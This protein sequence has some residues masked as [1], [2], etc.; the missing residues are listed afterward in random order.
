MV[1]VLSFFLFPSVDTNRHIK[2]DPLGEEEHLQEQLETI[3][4]IIRC[5]FQEMGAKIFSLFD[6]LAG[7]FQK[8]VS[9]PNVDQNLLAL[10]EGKLAWLVYIIGAILGGRLN[11]CAATE[12]DSFDGNLCC[13]VLKLQTIHDQRLP[14]VCYF[15]SLFLVPPSLL[16]LQ[17]VGSRSIFFNF[18]YFS[19]GNGLL[20]N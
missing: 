12:N 13:R 2:K 7:E 1:P 8:L 18:A 20:M 5:A 17:W 3:P 15:I 19:S 6:P 4:F 16:S 9:T 14:S 10:A 11:Q